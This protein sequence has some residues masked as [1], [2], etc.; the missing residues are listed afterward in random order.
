MARGDLAA[1]ERSVRQSAL[2]ATITFDEAA[3]WLEVG[4]ARILARLA[5]GELFAFVADDEM[6][7]PAWQF[8]DD[9]ERP[10]L[11]QLSTLIEAFD[12]DMHPTAILGF[13]TTPHSSTQIDGIPTT[14]IEWL[15]R[16]RPVQ[17]LVEIL[18]VR[19]LM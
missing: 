18:R 19:R 8:T 15:A 17:P 11:D 10:V 16:G 14:P 4:S 2:D 12:D 3:D 9:P 6:L 5:S 1:L 13:M 7:F